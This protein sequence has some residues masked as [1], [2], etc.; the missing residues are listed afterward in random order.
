MSAPNL[1][2]MKNYENGALRQAAIC[3]QKNEGNLLRLWYRYHCRIFGKDNIYIIDNNSDDPVT[4]FILQEIRDIHPSSISE[5]PASYSV[6]QKGIA[7]KELIS[8]IKSQYDIVFPLD[9]DE[10]LYVINDQGAM[11]NDS[12]SIMIESS[13]FHKSQLPL[14]RISNSLINIPRSSNGYVLTN[15]KKS[16]LRS[17]INL[18]LDAGFHFYDWSKSCSTISEALIYQSNFGHLHMHNK[19]F[20]FLLRSATEKLKNRIHDFSPQSLAGFKGAGSH[21]VK[22]FFM[23]EAQYL[24]GFNDKTRIDI[25]HFFSSFGLTLPY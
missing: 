6:D 21:L 13:T 20:E 5:T 24:D 19:P 15:I 4:K 23:T 16:A 8:E 9:C 18:Y 1:L 12:N 22:Y 25:S 7:V 3:M 17:D 2:F 14:A 10:F 11:V